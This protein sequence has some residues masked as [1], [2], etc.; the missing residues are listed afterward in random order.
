MAEDTE[1]SEAVCPPC[2]VALEMTEQGG[3][4][5]TDTYTCGSCGTAY[6]F[7]TPPDQDWAPPRT[8]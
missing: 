6:K 8:S 1:L 5:G 4:F 7:R 3:P 2:K